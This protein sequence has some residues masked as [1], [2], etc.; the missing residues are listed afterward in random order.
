VEV[1]RSE[2][3]V[4]LVV[5]LIVKGR[6]GGAIMSSTVSLRRLGECVRRRMRQVY[7]LNEGGGGAADV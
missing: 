6:A 7:E 1:R 3:V 5:D 4:S 2:A